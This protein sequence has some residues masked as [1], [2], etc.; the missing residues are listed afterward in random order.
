MSA[1]NWG[2]DV[3]DD[4]G[5]QVLPPMQE[6]AV[7]EDGLKT[8]TEYAYNDKGEKLKI[9]K[10]V[11]VTKKK[12]RANKKVLTRKEWTKFGLVKGKP[13]GVDRL[14][15]FY[16]DEAQ[17]DLRPRTLGVEDEEEE[18]SKL[19]NLEKDGKTSIVVCRF[20]GETG[21]WT[22]K[23]PKRKAGDALP[24]SGSSMGGGMGGGTDGKYVPMHLRKDAKGQAMRDRRDDFHSLR[25]T[26]ISK[27]TTETDLRNLFGNFGHLTRVFL[28]RDRQTQESRGFA[29]ISFAGRSDAEKAIVHLDGHGYDSLILHV[30]W[31]KP[32]DPK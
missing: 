13:R 24:E 1:G 30:E 27:D 19:D 18:T 23:C 8:V 26:N 22:L 29:F 4:D 28:A 16:A 17:F 32:R 14:T 7:G 20:C 31:A 12:V 25:V 9:V 5:S 11:K 15:T 2:D 21:H 10:V 6:T 3:S